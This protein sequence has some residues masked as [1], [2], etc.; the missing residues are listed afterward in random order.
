VPDDDPR[1]KTIVIKT[2]H[3]S[4]KHIPASD[5][6]MA[7]SSKGT[8]HSGYLGGGGGPDRPS[9]LCADMEGKLKGKERE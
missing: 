2:R 3:K 4:I 6:E 1:L 9:S 7:K 5:R 8:I